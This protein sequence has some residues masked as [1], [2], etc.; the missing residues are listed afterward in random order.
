MKK[1]VAS[2]FLAVVLFGCSAQRT[3]ESLSKLEFKI[4][5]VSDFE[6]LD[7]SV[8][9][10]NALGD[11]SPTELL[12]L[13][14][15][16][17]RGNLP[18]SFTLNVAVQNPNTRD[19][20]SDYLGLEIVS[21]PWEFYFNDRQILSGDISSPIQLHGNSATKIIPIKI[22]LNILEIVNKKNINDLLGTVLNFEGKGS[23]SKISLYA[24]PVVG[25]ILG[26]INYPEKIKIVDHKFTSK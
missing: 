19:G 9:G 6:L 17:S 23:T 4:D 11:F 26:N 14:P 12:K 22:S 5:S 10:K 8:S 25:T 1:I 18:A 20:F 24:K 2:L 13:V 21:L 7:M 15:A 16:F 3:L